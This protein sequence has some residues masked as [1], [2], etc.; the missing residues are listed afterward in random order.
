MGLILNNLM[1]LTT[2]FKLQELDV[3]H[4]Y[5]YVFMCQHLKPDLRWRSL[6]EKPI[7]QRWTR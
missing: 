6:E 2:V 1:N 7:T 3:I 4:S 5:V